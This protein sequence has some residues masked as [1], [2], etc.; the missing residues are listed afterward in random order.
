MKVLDIGCNS[1]E[2]SLA[3]ARHLGARR[4]V[5]CDIDSK[6]VEDAIANRDSFVKSL[7]SDQDAE[8]PEN[9]KHVPK[10]GKAGGTCSV[11]FKNQDFLE[12]P[13]EKDGGEKQEL[14]DAILCFSVTKWIHFTHGDK[15]IRKLFRRVFRKLNPGGL[16][17]L[18]P[19]EW[20]SYKKKRHLTP[21]IR[22]TVAGIQLHPGQFDSFLKELGFEAVAVIEPP[23]D[24]VEGFK[25]FI[26]V[27]KK[28]AEEEEIEEAEK[29][30]EKAPPEEPPIQNKKK[31]KA[32]GA[33]AKEED[34]KAEAKLED[35]KA[36]KKAEKKQKVVEAEELE[37]KPAPT[38]KK[39]QAAAAS[40]AV[41]AKEPEVEGDGEVEPEH[42]V[43]KKK[44]RCSEMGSNKKVE[45]K[46]KKAPAEEQ[47]E[48]VKEDDGD[49]D[50]PP[51]KRKKG[52]KKKQKAA[53][54]A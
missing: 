17:V 37:D 3:V 39:A 46:K 43:K 18:E 4:V 44:R 50:G 21:Q 28:P 5:G 14:Y 11:T 33:K 36:K 31:K 30:L 53:H 1:G 2:I 48:E 32:E 52:P 23:A 9:T 15:G 45:K 49:E 6:L 47:H 27:Y 8:A 38:R 41:A 12:A 54:N 19:Q 42:L 29:E 34:A 24:A 13:E 10:R 22:K 20:R 51:T 16:F 35:A 26:R 7:S 25:R 40:A